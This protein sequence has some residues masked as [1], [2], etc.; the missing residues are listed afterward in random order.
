MPVGHAYTSPVADESGGVKVKPQSHWNAPHVVNVDLASEVTGNLAVSHLNSGSGASNTTFW[1]GD[2]AWATPSGGAGSPA[3]SD[4]QIQYNNSGSFGA[5]SSLTWDGTLNVAGDASHDSANFSSVAKVNVAQRVILNTTGNISG[6]LGGSGDV[7]IYTDN[8]NNGSGA[9]MLSMKDDATNL[10]YGVASLDTNAHNL[11]KGKVDVGV[12]TNGGSVGGRLNVYNGGGAPTANQDSNAMVV[13]DAGI[14]TA[15]NVWFNIP[16]ASESPGSSGTFGF[17]ES[18]VYKSGMAYLNVDGVLSLQ[19]NIANPFATTGFFIDRLGN[20]GVNTRTPVAGLDVASNAATTAPAT[21]FSFSYNSNPGD[22]Y[23]IA[24]GTDRAFSIYSHNSTL[25]IYENIGATSDQG[26]PNDG[27]GY[28]V[29]FN[30]TASIDPG[31]DNYII[32]DYTLDQYFSTGATTSFSL[33]GSTIPDSSGFPVLSPTS[34]TLPAA[35]FRGI[36]TGDGGAS[37]IKISSSGNVGINTINP[38][39]PLHLVVSGSTFTPVGDEVFIIQRN[40]STANNAISSI[41]AGASGIAQM[42]FGDTSNTGAGSLYK[43]SMSFYNSDSHFQWEIANTPYLYL[44]SG[45]NFGVRTSTP[46]QPFDVNGN[47]RFRAAIYDQTNAAGSNGNIFTNNGSGGAWASVASLGLATT[48]ALPTLAPSI[49]ATVTG[50]DAKAIASTTLYTV[51][52]GKTAVITQVVVRCTA[53]TAI[54]NGP[55]IN[56]NTVSAGDIFSSVNIAALTSANKIYGFSLVGMSLSVAPAATVKAGLTSGAT[57]TSQTI[58]F[59]V[60]GYLE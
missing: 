23:F 28:E 42:R 19:T 60:I 26:D 38:L 43:G 22:P 10:Q 48:A 6:G 59:D 16:N 32:Y 53:A 14:G 34:V 9:V 58:Q 8:S 29:D 18:G 52:A 44:I 1:R 30:W 13:F 55:T 41:V 54:T 40:G 36:I 4:T 51:P 49:L 35:T 2:G 20:T 17:T 50:V 24:D 45:G 3:G 56:I 11:F 39:A 21:N 7:G 12:A 5:S 37:G 25:G 15:A 33:F 27:Q 46:S 57:G 47:V 31:V